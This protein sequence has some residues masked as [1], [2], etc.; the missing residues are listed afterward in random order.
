LSVAL[1]RPGEQR[2][3]FARAVPVVE[4]STASFTVPSGVVPD[5]H[6]AI[7][8]TLCAE[9]ADGTRRSDPIWVIQVHRLTL[10]REGRGPASARRRIEETGEGLPEY[11]E[12]LGDREGVRSVI[13]FLRNTS[14]R[15]FDGDGRPGGVSRFRLRMSD[16]FRPDIAPARLA[17]DEA[18]ATGLE[19]AIYEFVD[20]HE[21]QRLLRHA[22]SGNINGLPNFLDI[23]TALVRLLYVYYG[24]GVVKKGHL[25]DKL[26]RYIQ[27]AIGDP[28]GELD[29][30]LPT[31]AGNLGVAADGLIEVGREANL[32]GHLSATLL[33][34]QKVRLSIP[35]TP[36]S[37][38]ECLPYM[39]RLLREALE[40]TGLGTASGE[41]ILQALQSY[42]MFE[43]IELLGYQILL[44]SRI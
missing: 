3:P 6:G 18:G 7:L 4:E 41:Q 43:E 19:A 26:L 29:G 15:Y 10:E 24:R 25:I 16:P 44:S 42:A 36:P 5:S 9:T 2:D 34:A 21:R 28:D 33:I 11:L 17:H 1:R 37:L 13:E 27:I 23:F 40:S 38:A 31:I 32:S 12:A 35:P 20:R 30:F 14:I 22:R 39:G 8:A